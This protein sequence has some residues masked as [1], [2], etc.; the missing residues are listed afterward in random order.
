MTQNLKTEIAPLT[1]PGVDI[2]SG[3]AEAAKYLRA[4]ANPSRLVLLCELFEGEKSVGELEEAS[5][6]SQAYVSQQLARLRGE[7]LVKGR[8]S[9]RVVYYSL[10]DDKVRPMIEFLHGQFCDD[11]TTSKG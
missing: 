2:R 8:R 1:A 6:F 11:T 10:C 4:L 3:A 5:G 7:S 9:G